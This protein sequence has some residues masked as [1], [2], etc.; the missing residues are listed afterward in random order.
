MIFCSLYSGSSGN[1]IFISSNNA[2]ILVDA[3]L[4]GKAI[5]KGLSDI[6]ENPSELNG[7]LIT[8]E[9]VDHIKGVGILSRRYNIPIY[10]NELTWKAI[11]NSLGKIREEN[12]K[13]IENNYISIKDMDIFTYNIPHDAVAPSGYSICSG[14]KKACIATDMGYFPENVKEQ[15]WD[16][17][18][19][20]LESNHDEEMVKFGPYPYNLKRRILSNIGHLSNE[21][22]GKA[23]T[24]I[25][26]GRQKRVVL[27]HLSKINNMPDLAYQTVINVLNQAKID[28]KSEILLA[29]ADRDKPSSYIEF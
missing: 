7:I 10:A 24:Q 6:K 22:C 25:L 5:E 9:H 2:K 14:G 18:I 28:T 11:G 13:K 23:I 3:G 15:L 29:L 20:L 4:S 21:A 19:V 16:A 1:S 27:G 26:N 17:D 8:H 12:I